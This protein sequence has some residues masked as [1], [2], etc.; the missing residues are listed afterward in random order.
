MISV[1]SN[2]VSTT[3]TLENKT[4]GLQAQIVYTA[5]LRHPWLYKQIKFTNTGTKPFLLRTVEVEHLKV[6]GEK[7]TYA[8]NPSFPDLSD[9]G[10]PVYTQ[11]L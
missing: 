7:I 4:L 3:A 5:A 9:W 8:V 10:Q 6:S 1:D 11:S 2:N